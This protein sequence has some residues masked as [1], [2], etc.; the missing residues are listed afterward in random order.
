MNNIL[1]QLFDG[2]YS[3]DI[4][5]TLEMKQAAHALD[6]FEEQ[7]VAAL[8]MQCLND[9]LEAS[10]T[11]AHLE[12]QAYFNKGVQLCLSFLVEGLRPS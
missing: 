3:A 12:N 1:Q 9:F 11:L 6:P 7:I 8:G 4:Q 10:L 5:V 2:Q